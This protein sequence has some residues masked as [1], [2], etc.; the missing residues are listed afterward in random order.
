[1]YV[2]MEPQNYSNPAAASRDSY[3]FLTGLPVELKIEILRQLPEFDCVNQLI[4]T[5]SLFQEVVQKYQYS[6][7]ESIIK[8][9]LGALWKQAR[10]LLVLQSKLNRVARGSHAETAGLGILEGG[11]KVGIA[12]IFQIMSNAR[13]IGR[14]RGSFISVIRPYSARF[15]AGHIPAIDLVY[16]GLTA[17]NIFRI[18][19]GYYSVWIILLA[20]APGVRELLEQRRIK[21]LKGE[22][23]GKDLTIEEELEIHQKGHFN[24]EEYI[25]YESREAELEELLWVFGAAWLFRFLPNL[26]LE[27]IGRPYEE[28]CME[29]EDKLKAEA[30]IQIH[31]HGVR[32]VYPPDNEDADLN[33]LGNLFMFGP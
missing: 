15:D 32:R 31:L 26:G 24:L 6:I 19:R 22:D 9:Q 14:V 5:D 27:I 23:L 17:D 28:W 33:Y 16:E 12:E 4:L 11:S 13:E 30:R 7:C 10:Q 18:D 25:Q 21:A 8:N 20:C 29:N 3:S 1:M 2:T